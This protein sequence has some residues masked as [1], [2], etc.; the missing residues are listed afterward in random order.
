MTATPAPATSPPP[1]SLEIAET[2]QGFEPQAITVERGQVVHVTF[3]NKGKDTH[4]LRIAGGAQFGTSADVVF[5]TPAVT[6]G[7]SASGDWR[8][9]SQAGKRLFRCDLHP[10]HTGVITIR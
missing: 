5:G 7:Q 3:V 6:A 10:N 8:A 2:D 4:N 1:I 9:P